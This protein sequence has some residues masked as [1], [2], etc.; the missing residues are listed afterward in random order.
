MKPAH[1]PRQRDSY[2]ISKELEKLSYD[3]AVYDRQKRLM[4]IYTAIYFVLWPLAWVTSIAAATT[5]DAG[6][7]VLAV[8]LFVLA[9]F[10]F[11]KQRVTTRIV[12]IHR[13]LADNV[14]R[15]GLI[16]IATDVVEK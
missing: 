15:R 12:G 6:F 4:T 5:M 1:D 8:T 16:A 10:A 7:I 2:A 3:L 14:R 9:I 11:Y 13:P